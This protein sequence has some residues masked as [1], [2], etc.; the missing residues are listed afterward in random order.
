M[1]IK[2]ST[3]LTLDYFLK[4][5]RMAQLL[6]FQDMEN[7]IDSGKNHYIPYSLTGCFCTDGAKSPIE[8]LFFFAFTKRCDEKCK[9]DDICYYIYL[10]P[11]HKIEVNGKTYYADFYVDF[12]NIDE[13]TRRRAENLKLIIECDG[14]DFHQKT[15][16]QVKHD[17]ERD[18]D[19]KMA[20]YEVLHFSGSQIYN[21]PYKCVDDVIDFIH[22][23]VTDK[24][25][26]LK[27]LGLGE[28]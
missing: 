26:V 3:E 7:S 24:E 6:F 23:R 22:S 2:K 16:A 14:H 5:P 15:K 19:L 25:E 20:G 21:D 10:E 9:D 27:E 11:Q 18:F 13:V 8:Q 4:L 1:K 28:E 17:N 12:D